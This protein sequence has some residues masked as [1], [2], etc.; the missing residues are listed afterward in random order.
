MAYD[1]ISRLLKDGY[2][3]KIKGN[4]G[5]TAYLV[6]TQPLVGHDYCA[7][8]RYPGGDCCHDLESIKA[9]F[10]VLEQYPPDVQ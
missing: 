9:H 7:I 10:T 2:P 1:S 5:Y 3:W 4:G 6:D 8:Y